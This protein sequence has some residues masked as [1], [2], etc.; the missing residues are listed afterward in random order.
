MKLTHSETNE[1]YV[2]SLQII[3]DP[4]ALRHVIF[5]P[6]LLKRAQQQYEEN[7]IPREAPCGVDSRLPPP[8]AYNNGYISLAALPDWQKNKQI[9]EVFSDSV[10]CDFCNLFY[11]SLH[12]TGSTGRKRSTENGIVR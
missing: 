10:I 9:L 6:P 3:A 2:H 8:P 5:L 11:F 12:C 7:I 4:S 1:T